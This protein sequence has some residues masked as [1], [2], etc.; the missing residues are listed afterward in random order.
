MLHLFRLILHELYD[1]SS[2]V[3]YECNHVAHHLT[4]ATISP[5]SLHMCS[6]Y[7]NIAYTNRPESYRVLFTFRVVVKIVNVFCWS[8]GIMMFHTVTVFLF[9]RRYTKQKLSQGN[10]MGVIIPYASSNLMKG[11]EFPY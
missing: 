1:G 2:D 10:Y 5:N 3:H 8:H 9:L 4:N 11:Q 7:C 6:F